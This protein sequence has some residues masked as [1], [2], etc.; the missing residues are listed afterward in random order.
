[1]RKELQFDVCR[2][3]A[4]HDHSQTDSSMSNCYLHRSKRLTGLLEI[5]KIDV[6]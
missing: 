6:G 1:M 4:A 5:N 2:D 3:R